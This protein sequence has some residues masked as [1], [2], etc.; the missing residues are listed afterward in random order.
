M[1]VYVRA[2]TLNVPAPSLSDGSDSTIPDPDEIFPE[3]KGTIGMI[4]KVISEVFNNCW[5]TLD[6]KT[7]EKGKDP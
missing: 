5:D 6:K 7:T 3:R 4:D 2:E 1:P